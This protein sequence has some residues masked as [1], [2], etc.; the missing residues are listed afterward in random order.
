[1][2]TKLFA[3]LV[4]AAGLLAGGPAFG[5]DKHE[6]GKGRA[7][8]KGHSVAAVHRSGGNHSVAVAHRRAGGARVAVSHG[9]A[10]RGS[11]VAT[12]RPEHSGKSVALAGNA[13]SS[14]GSGKYDGG[15]GHYK[16][17]FQSHAGWAPGHE[18]YWNGRHYR[19]YDNAWFIIDPVP[20]YYGADYGYYGGGSVGAAVQ[21]Q[22]ARDGYYRGPVDGV[23]GPGTRS[24]IAAYQRDNGLHVTGTI[25]GR[26]LASLGIS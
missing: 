17:A 19:W 24:A 4:L 1:M 16:Y 13:Y 15:K 11:T 18:Y 9:R 26:L 14:R 10:V 6:G 21:A 7:V 23:I 5:Y 20:Y 22:L 25:N 3:V 8:A 12:R 2:K